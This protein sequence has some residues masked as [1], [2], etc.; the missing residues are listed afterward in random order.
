MD[1]IK[2]DKWSEWVINY[3]KLIAKQKI[4]SND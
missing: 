3:K 4:W 2:Q 1:A